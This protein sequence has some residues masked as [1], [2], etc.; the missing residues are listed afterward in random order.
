MYDVMNN[1]KRFF[2]R[3]KNLVRGVLSLIA[4]SAGKVAEKA[5]STTHISIEATVARNSRLMSISPGSPKPPTREAPKKKAAPA[6][7]NNGKMLARLYLESL[8]R[9]VGEERRTVMCHYLPLCVPLLS[10]T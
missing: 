3:T 8:A 10:V 9:R 4:C 1:C 7:A 5:E 6:N 2:V